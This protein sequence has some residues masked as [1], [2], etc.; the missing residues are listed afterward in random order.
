MNKRRVAV[1]GAVV[2]AVTA[3]GSWWFRSGDPPEPV[4][5]GKTLGAWLDDR[6]ATAQGPVVLSDEA[7]SAVRAIGPEAVPTLLAWI[8]A[9]DPMIIYNAKILLE[10]RLK[11]PVRLP[12]NTNQDKRTRAE[13]GF[14]VL[15]PVAR[16]AFPALVAL[17]LN[18]SDEYQRV[19]AINALTQSDAETMRRLAEG[20]R[21]SN[22][23][24]RLRAVFALSCL[25]I[26]PDEVCLPALEGATKDPDTQVRAKATQA[27]GVFHQSLKSCVDSLKHRDPEWMARAARM[28]GGYRSRARAFLPDLE[29]VALDDDPQVRAKATQAIGVFHQSLK[30]CVDSLKHRDPEWMARAA[31]MVGGYRSRARAFLPD[32]EAVALDDDPEVRAAVAEAIRQVRGGDPLPA[33]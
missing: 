7:A 16:P 11:L 12:I 26:A 33:D 19:D 25:R 24:V 22:R 4:Y 3:L 10:D 8:R 14:R 20:L 30:S 2:V 15:G 18:S 28:V 27:I 1:A 32:L 6:R 13:Y 21:S 17:A 29:A 9:S 5:G 23:E 31:R